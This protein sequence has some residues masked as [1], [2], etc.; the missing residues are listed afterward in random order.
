M[1]S[2][3]NVSAQTPEEIAAD[4]EKWRISNVLPSD[5]RHSD[6]KRYLD[7]IRKLGIKVEQVGVSNANREIYQMEWGRGPLKVFM[8]SQMHGDEPTATPALIDLFVFLQKNADR[9]DVKLI[10]EKITLRAVPMLNPDG[11]EQFIRRNLQGID[12]NRDALDLATPEARIL[13]RL[14]DDWNPAI[15]FNLHN[16]QELTTAGNA[17]RQAAISFLVVFGD[18]EKTVDAGQE[19]NM[20]LAS[21]MTRALQRF[22][23]GHIGRYSDEWTPTA[24]GDNFSAWGTPTILIETGGLHGRDEMFLVKMNFVAFMT[25]LNA[26]ATG[27]EANESTA[28][29]L[30]LPLNGSGI[31]AHV[32][33]RNATVVN[34]GRPS[35]GESVVVAVR[36]RRRASFAQAYLITSVARDTR[37]VG[38]SEYNAAG[39]YIVQRF[40][41]LRES[42]LAEFYFYKKDRNIDW[43]SPDLEKEFP[44]DAVF[45]GGKFIKGSLPA[46]R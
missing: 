44:P 27:S 46:I 29:Y 34:S 35:N 13:K 5:T 26:L 19:R 10:A 42:E 33:F 4:W 39:Y 16:Q 8:W 6:V 41:R 38:L 2:L 23:P 40:G 9:P 15:G 14:R 28:P 36:Q 37:L 20:R 18:P 25:A 7:E 30:S 32:I 11:A 45:S 21:A 12:I 1:V 17:P 31:L 3:L 43:T 22:I 24:F